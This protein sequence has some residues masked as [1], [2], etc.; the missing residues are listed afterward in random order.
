MAKRTRNICD[1]VIGM[2]H[3]VTAAE[4]AA[5]PAEPVV[6]QGGNNPQGAPAHRTVFVGAKGL[7]RA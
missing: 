3:P 7:R 1:T 2:D 4:S 6:G 5:K